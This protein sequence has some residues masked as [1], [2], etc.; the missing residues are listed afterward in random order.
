MQKKC[1][2]PGGTRWIEQAPT[3]T[4]RYRVECAECREFIKWGNLAQLEALVNAG[5]PG[6]LVS[7]EESLAPPSPTLDA[8]FI[9][10]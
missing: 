5:E 10:D 1:T 6:E 2:C 8:F 3:S 4:S 9:K 7:Y